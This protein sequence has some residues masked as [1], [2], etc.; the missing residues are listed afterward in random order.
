MVV[1]YTIYGRD[2]VRCHIGRMLLLECKCNR[3]LMET[4]LS[5]RHERSADALLHLHDNLCTCVVLERISYV[6]T[7][8][9]TIGYL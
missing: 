5:A 9:N 7:V 1:F 2:D 4:L 6:L 3:R 8:A